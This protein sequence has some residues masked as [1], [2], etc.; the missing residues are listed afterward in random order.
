MKAIY[1]PISKG[2][3]AM[4]PL[5]L[6]SFTAPSEPARSELAAPLSPQTT[7][8][9][10]LL[11]SVEQFLSATAGLR[12]FILPIAFFLSGATLMWLLLHS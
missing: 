3:T 1:R 8:S 11:P 2:S 12:R 4:L 7:D 6:K 9:P 5:M 10:R